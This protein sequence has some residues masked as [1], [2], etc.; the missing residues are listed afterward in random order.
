MCVYDLFMD[1]IDMH[2]GGYGIDR[3]DRVLWVDGKG[4]V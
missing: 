1:V 4:D 2:R 3:V